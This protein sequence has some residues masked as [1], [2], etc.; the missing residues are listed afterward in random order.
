MKF[1]GPIF[2]SAIA[3]TFVLAAFYPRPVDNSQREAILMR[4]V[5]TFLNQ[6]HYSPKD[7]ND[8]F[9]TDLHEFYVNRLDGTRRYLTQSDIDQLNQYK[10]ELDNQINT[11]DY[12]FF[13][14]SVELLENGIAKAESYYKEILAEPFDF[15][16]DESFEL[17]GEK[18]G[19]AQ[20][21]AELREYW[22][23][24]LKY[25]TMTR[26]A[27]KLDRQEKNKNEDKEEK[28]LAELE[29]EAR[30]DVLEMYDGVFNRISKIK[31]NDRLSFYLNSITSLFDPHSNYYKPIDKE[32]FDISMSGRLEGIGARLTQDGD[33]VKVSE[34]VTGGPAW[35]GKELD[36]K[37]LITK[38][39]QGED[40]DWIDVTGWSLD[41]VVQQ[42]RGKK[43]TTVRL[44]IRK[45][46]GTVD[47]I[48]IVRDVIN[49]EE[50]YARSLILEADEQGSKI[51]YIFVPKF[52]ADFDD[53]DGRFVAKDV[54]A[55]LEK[56]KAEGIDGVVLDLRNNGGGSLM[57]V[58]RMTG[59]FIERG[60]IVQTKSRI[61]DPDIYRDTDSKVV[62][63]GP[64]AVMTNGFSA[65]ASEILAGAIQDYNRGVVVG[66]KA[67]FGKGTV[68]RFFPLDRAVRGME[69]VKPLGEIKL[70][71]QKFFRITGAS[72]QLRGVIPD[73]IL[74][75]RYHN[76]EL[77]EREE[78]Y[79]LAWSEIE[80]V[81][82]DQDVYQIPDPQVL[83]QRS[84]DRLENSAI[85][86]RILENARKLEVQREDSE[87]SLNLEAYRAYRQK[88]QEEN[89]AFNDLFDDEVIPVVQ[90]PQADLEKVNSNEEEKARNE[91][92]V[93]GVATDVY[94]KE[95]LHIL[96]DMIKAS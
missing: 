63:D 82:F 90:N 33:Y 41:D 43:G 18:R 4:T 73:V 85:F 64:L 44:T 74:P 35:Q 17:D 54:E 21:D 9:S 71:T 52:Y 39:A 26:L 60:P 37:D 48:S 66:S 42:I 31:R 34:I 57:E 23:K 62:Y 15:T 55:E 78:D 20:S 12:T 93:E 81:A 72:N 76:I 96:E 87:Y 38:V 84:A 95:T 22:R 29:E 75:D 19:Y 30:E 10:T 86:N 77:G 58:V 36:E 91:E 92:F 40:G 70:T 47:E 53:P 61:S 2:V 69:E 79:P 88:Q 6:L 16:V 49:I 13:D 46:D 28:S 8:E 50:T 67:T 11:G 89:E 80:P 65:S 59:L 1:R 14:L 3:I 7:I 56:L 24:I 51:G 25:E 45:V 68:Q 5:L 27:R 83:A 94:I 32:N